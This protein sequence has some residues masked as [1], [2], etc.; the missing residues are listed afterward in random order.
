LTYT[1]N[2]ASTCITATL[3]WLYC[4]AEG[5]TYKLQSQDIKSTIATKTETTHCTWH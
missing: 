3:Y 1:R 4:W 5:Q 2:I